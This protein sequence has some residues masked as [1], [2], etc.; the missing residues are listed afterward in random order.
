MLHFFIK[1]KKF[2][3]EV[4]IKYTTMKMKWVTPQTKPAYPIKILSLNETHSLNWR[5]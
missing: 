1:K 4:L 5:S 2:S 3:A